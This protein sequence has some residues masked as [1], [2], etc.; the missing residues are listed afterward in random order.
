M[1]RFDSF[2]QACRAFFGEDRPV[3]IP[4][5][6]ELTTKDKVELSEM[7][8]AEGFEHKPYEPP[9]VTDGGLLLDT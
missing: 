2:I 1:P 5:F 6:K 7:L 4:E 3:S 8:I 9:G